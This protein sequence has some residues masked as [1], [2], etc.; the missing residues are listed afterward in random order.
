[1][2]VGSVVRR[3]A[4]AVGMIAAVLASASAGWATAQPSSTVPPPSATTSTRSGGG[5]GDGFTPT[6]RAPATATRGGS[7]SVRGTNWVCGEVTI[8]PPWATTPTTAAGTSPP[9]AVVT[10]DVGYDY[11]FSA[12]VPV[13]KAAAL[14]ASTLWVSCTADPDITDSVSVRI[15]AVPVVTEPI[16]TG[17]PPA[18]DPPVVT[19]APPAVD[20]V[21]P[22]AEAQGPDGSS[23]SPS[24][25]PVG[26]VGLLLVAGVIALAVRERTRAPDPAPVIG[27]S[28]APEPRAPEVGVRV[29]ADP[30][31]RLE[32]RTVPAQVPT[33]E[34]R[35]HRPEP[36]ITVRE[37]R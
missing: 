11:T 2:T 34:I 18:V 1:M 10:A 36:F 6:L 35:T 21:P 19:E 27:A 7:I 13:P 25:G 26:L 29:H 37:V 28:V 32:I 31:P 17:A 30:R 12:S 4:W 3:R 22:T 16:V 23:G 5:T 8:V 33:V 9:L 14:G 15:L 24:A 20:P